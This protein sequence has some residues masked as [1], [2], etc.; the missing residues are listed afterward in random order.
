[1]MML[2]KGIALLAI[3]STLILI[4]GYITHIILSPETSEKQ[5]KQPE[6]EYKNHLP[7]DQNKPSKKGVEFPPKEE[8]SVKFVDSS[9]AIA[10]GKTSGTFHTGQEAD[11]MLSGFD[12]NRTGGALVFNHPSGIASDGKHLF[13]VDTFNNRVLI[14][15]KLPEDNVPPDIVLGQK[16]FYSNDPG[17]ERDQMNW[18]FSITT[19]GK[20]LVVS[21]VNNNRILIWN[22]IPT[23]NGEPADII[24]KGGGSY[25]KAPNE[26]RLPGAAW[27][28]WT[29]GNK[30]VITNTWSDGSILIWNRFPTKENQP[31]DIVLNIPEMGTPRHIT[32][33]GKHLI[34]GDHNARVPGKPET[35]AF[36]WKEFPTSQNQSYDFY[37]SRGFGWLRGAFFDDDKLLLLGGEGSWIRIW[38]KF[39]ESENDKPD[40]KLNLES[41]GLEP[42]DYMSV[43]IAGEKIY[44]SHGN[45]NRVIGYKSIPT[46][47]NQE[48]DFVIGAPDLH[49]NSLE[50]NFFIQN[51]V[52]V[53]NGKN[54]FIASDFDRKLYVWKNLPD[55][56]GAYPDIVY[57]LPMQPWDIALKKNILTL[58]GEKTVYIWKKLPLN[59]NLPDITI[60]DGIGDIKFEELR[61]VAIDENYFYLSDSKAGKIYVWKG[62]PNKKTN[63]SPNFILNIKDPMRLDS[64]GRYLTVALNGQPFVKIYDI[65]NLS[66]NTSP[67]ATI[68]GP[69]KM[70][71]PQHAI[72]KYEMLFVGDTCNNRVLIWN[73][74][75]EALAGKWPPDAILGQS[76]LEESQPAI[77]KKGLI[78]P[79]GLSFDGNYLWVGEFKFS[80][81][82]LRFS[83]Y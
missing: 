19:D 49:T 42:D 67:T 79:G 36:F 47:F 59:G 71:L 48:P 41:A 11:I 46:Q 35:G 31:A 26:K 69:G 12:F 22:K 58:A 29:D 50:E 21:D 37:I 60:K 56:S 25:W 53:S 38:N 8:I 44:I 76:S 14:W 72:V 33:N 66:Q 75:E 73:K 27:G 18:P 63:P 15:N 7:K 64:N 9:Y 55:E 82:I 32:S 62:I 3:I 39:P 10:P 30:L 13:L 16:N 17:K 77:G 51:G 80:N 65:A 5:T 45:R 23:K 2:K 78:F 57:E 61:G 20:H 43:A 34:I 4:G 83:P 54:L 74:I 40:V 28:V 1:M 68:G 6:E 70:N 81:R 24:L 52:P